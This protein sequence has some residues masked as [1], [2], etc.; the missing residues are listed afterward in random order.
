[1]SAFGPLNLASPSGLVVQVN[2]NG[3]VRRIDHRDVMVNAFLGNELEGGAANLYLRRHGT[4]VEWTELLGPHSPGEVRVDGSGL[5]IAGEWAGLRFRVSLTLA[6]AAPAWFWHV[7]LDNVA[8]E[9]CRV[10][11]VFAQDIALASYGA[12]RLNEYYVSQYV[13]HTPLHHPSQGAVLAVR[14]NLAV[15]GR[16]PWLCI[17]SLRHAE[18]FCTDALQFHGL[19]TRAGGSPAALEAERLPGVRRQHEHSMAVLQDAPVSLLPGAGV[20]LGFF[21]WLEPDHPGVSSAADLVFADRALAQPEAAPPGSRAGVAAPRSATLF[22]DAPLLAATS[23]DPD[24]LVRHFGA[25]RVAVEEE[26]GALLS[27]FR[28]D[29][30]HV[31][32]PAKERATLRPHGQILRTGD[33]LEPDEASLTTTVWMGGVFH[34]MLTQGHVSINRFLSTTHS[35]LGLYRSHGQRVFA[36]VGGAWHLLGEPSAFEMTPSGARWLYASDDRLLEV[37]SWAAVE[38]HELW[39]AVRVLDGA[40]CRFLVSHH[41]ALNGDDGSEA[42]PARWTRDGRAVVVGCLPDT[43]VGRRFPHGAFRINIAPGPAIERVGADELLFSDGRSRGQPFVVLVTAPT[44]SL[45]L[46]IT[47][48]LTGAPPAELEADVADRC[49]AD[50]AKAGRFWH[51]M[52]GPLVLEAPASQDVTRVTAILPWLT[53]DAWIHHLAPRG[54]EQYSGGGWGTRDVC[55]GPVELLLAIGRAAAVRE[56]LL[57]VFRN[58]DEDGDWPQWFMFFERERTIRPQ[59]SHGDIVFWPLLALA[60][61]LLATDDVAVL[62]QEL[63]YFHPEG[64]ARAQH[65]SVLA[66]VER[67]LALIGRR[68]IAGTRLAAY[69]HGDWNDS[70]QPADPA[71]ARELCS[72]WTVT[73][74]YQT[75]ATLAQALRRTRHAAFAATLEAT[76]PGIQDDFQRLL[77]ADGVVAGMVRFPPGGA[78]EHWLHPNDRVTGVHYSLLPMIHAVLANLFTREQAVRHVEL[79]RRHLLAADGARLFDQPF[80][81]HGGLQRHFQRAETSTFFGREIGLMYMHAHL[82]WAQALAH[83]GDAEGAFHALRQ[84]NPVGLRDVVPNARLRQAN[85]YASS[86]DADFADRAEATARYDAVRSGTVG[87]EAGWRVY[88]SGAGIAVRLLR[89]SLLG[90]RLH[91]SSVCLDPVLPR[92]LDGLV[93]RI[94]LEDREVAVRYRVG[95]RGH[96]PLAITC[97]GQPLAFEREPHPYRTGG[98]VIA[99]DAL[100]QHLRDGDN[101]IEIEVA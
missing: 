35:Y 18:S 76:L 85:C 38:R 58:Q 49:A 53:H 70:L 96:G 80:P 78:A 66:H 13:D 50:A 60:Q 48:L 6:A 42:V 100:R 101:V 26:G 52:T 72:A 91:R 15:G 39:L 44:T 67:A 29:G 21:A 20:G 23:L 87:V 55:Q 75:V 69:G 56:L 82:R 47:G 83:L 9:P 4:R 73:L 93:A 68:V 1:M 3:S 77:V 22:S 62:E 32:L 98:A 86:S 28:P 84:A 61:Y 36:E 11:L 89:E 37:R 16:H 71:L 27:F 63:P 64:P 8:G 14:Q 34:S 51:G 99:M 74:H 65:A 92:T 57:C 30:A 45:G 95:A 43:D 12:V 5:E 31:V 33:R 17:G 81:Y 54:L 88:S 94:T 19:S 97:N 59:D 7:S 25:D 90:L 79:V 46:R 10:D 40:P 2:R 24:A 41:I